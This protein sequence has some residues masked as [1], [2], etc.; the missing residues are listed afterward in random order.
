VEASGDCR[1]RR[2]F[3]SPEHLLDAIEVVGRKIGERTLVG[4]K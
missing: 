2:R 3:W 1:Y 4:E